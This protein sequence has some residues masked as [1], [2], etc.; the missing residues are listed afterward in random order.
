MK[1]TMPKVSV[2]VPIFNVESYLRECLDSVV[3][4]TLR[5][6][7]IICINDGSTDGSLAIIE[8]YA[9]RDDRFVIIDKPNSGYGDSMNQGLQR[10]TGDYI[11]IVESDDWV[12]SNMFKELYRLAEKHNAQVAKS[13]FYSYYTTPEK[14]G[15]SGLKSNLIRDDEVHRPINP[16]SDFHRRI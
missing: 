8:E 1:V 11:G 10:A 7:E 13:E 9:K 15:M 2:L 16:H 5:S 14:R 12:E 6:L 3:N 4:Q